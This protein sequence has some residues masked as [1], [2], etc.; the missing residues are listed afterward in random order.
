[1]SIGVFDS[2]LGG[3]TVINELRKIYKNEDIIFFADTARLPYGNK[4]KEEIILYS[5]EIVKFL[6][7]KKVDR[8]LIACNTATASA[9]DYLL[10]K[11]NINIKGVIEYGAK[12]IFEEKRVGVI[13]TT[14]TINSNKYIE[15]INKLNKK[16]KI[17]SLATPLLVP[18]I[19]NGN[20]NSNELEITIKKYLDSLVC[21]ID[22]LI[23]GCTH[24][25]LLKD[26]IFKFYPKLKLIDPSE[27]LAK[28][29]NILEKKE[30]GKTYFYV[31]G[32]KE[33]FR[34]KLEN[35]FDYK[36]IIIEEYKC[37]NI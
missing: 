8:I 23:L 11:Y 12:A 22:S 5:D 4:T 24:Y 16:I 25:S 29:L 37:T 1:M 30:K 14:N 34:K 28:N 27:E 33:E 35:I 36:N 19:E 7:N 6:I 31:S 32:N 10:E 17:K 20:L 18:L 2:G 3:V 15:E 26:K 21:D 13:A 9:L